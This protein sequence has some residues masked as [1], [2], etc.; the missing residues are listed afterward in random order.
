MLRPI[1]AAMYNANVDT[2]T[3]S[4]ERDTIGQSEWT[5][6]TE[7]DVSICDASDDEFFS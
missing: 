6:L 1:E 2:S 4:D 5:G 3:L 7:C